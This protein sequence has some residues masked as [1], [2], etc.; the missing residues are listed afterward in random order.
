MN[1]FVA[2]VSRVCA[3]LKKTSVPFAL[4]GGIAVSAR[5]E[6]RFTRDVDFAVAVDQDEDAE[7]VVTFLKGR[8][9][10]INAIVE[11]E[12]RKR[13]ATVRLVSAMKEQP[14]VLV[15]LLFA[16]SGIEREIVEAAERIEVWNAVVLPVAALGH[17]IALKVLARNDKT[18]PQDAVDLHGLLAVADD[19]EIERAR[20][21]VLLI[22]KRGYNREKKLLRQLEEVVQNSAFNTKG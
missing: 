18:R 10:A 6:P 5:T 16:S 12:K 22:T 3:D 2:T 19:S 8:G 9:Y 17:L 11:Q 7:K 14:G 1:R 13:L 21:A 15:D 20:K 4:V